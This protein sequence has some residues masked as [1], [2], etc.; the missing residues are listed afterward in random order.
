MRERTRSLSQ[1]LMR[2]GQEW[3]SVQVR[4][5]GA[6][7]RLYD[8]FCVTL[9]LVHIG[10]PVFGFENAGSAKFG[11]VIL[12]AQRRTETGRLY[13]CAS[14]F[15]ARFSLVRHILMWFFTSSRNPYRETIEAKRT[16]RADALKHAPA[17]SAEKHQKFL[18]VTGNAFS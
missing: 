7:R 4:A 17:F 8:S 5:L 15:L 14:V 9:G 1:I 13:N 6:T 16:R 3:L 10:C 2:T 11:C 18:N 12:D